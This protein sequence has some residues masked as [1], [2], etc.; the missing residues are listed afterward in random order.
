MHANRKSEESVV[1]AKPANKGAAEALAE[2]VEE[3]D[4]TERNARE[5]ALRRTPSRTKRESRG[6]WGVREA[7]RQDST[8]K[9]T[10]LLHHIDEDCLR[11]AFF[12]L[13]K[14]AAVG[15]DEVTWQDYERNLEANLGD[16]QGRIHRGAYRAKPSRRV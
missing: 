1:P 7:A 10:A 11:D 2:S 4:S 5:A 6:L 14:T 9:F 15:V 13:K 12:N 16:L 8:L 3:R